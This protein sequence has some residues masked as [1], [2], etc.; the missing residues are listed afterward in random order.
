MILVFYVVLL[1]VRLILSLAFDDN[2]MSSL[3]F[4]GRVKVA[5]TDDDENG[6]DSVYTVTNLATMMVGVLVVMGCDR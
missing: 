5:D 4:S 6:D 1:S 3:L 2:Q